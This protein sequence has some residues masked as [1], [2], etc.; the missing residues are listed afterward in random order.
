MAMRSELTRTSRF[1]SRILRHDP[2]LIGI[3][4]DAAG[5]ADIDTLLTAAE[6]SG[7]TIPRE[8]LDE[9]VATN[10]KQRFAISEHGQ[11][12]RARQGH[13]IPVDLGLEPM[14]PPPELY[15]GTVDRFLPSIREH[16]LRPGSRHAVHLSADAETAVKVGSRRGK[17]VV[18][19]VDATGAA[20]AGVLFTRSE[21]GVWLTD[22]VPP[23]FLRFPEDASIEERR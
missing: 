11:K 3:T 19:V 17:P 22:A 4:L 23:E 21:N 5:W 7:R 1:L 14:T 2:G 20:A 9:I 16:G 15:H 18:L 12:I 6:A 8:T 13:S 10:D